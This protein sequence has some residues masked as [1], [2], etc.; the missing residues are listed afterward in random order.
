MPFS[1]NSGHVWHSRYHDDHQ[2]R[3]HELYKVTTPASG[4]PLRVPAVNYTHHY[5]SLHAAVFNQ[6]QNLC[7]K[8]ELHITP[9]TNQCY[10]IWI[11]C[12]SFS[13]MHCVVSVK[14]RCVPNN[15]NIG[16]FLLGKVGMSIITVVL[17]VLGLHGLYG[18]LR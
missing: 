6:L 18:F 10:F 15:L 14:Y 11:F 2:C 8:P 4:W 17:V 13:K 3:V 1:S 7:L 9:Y 12:F 16:L 5:W